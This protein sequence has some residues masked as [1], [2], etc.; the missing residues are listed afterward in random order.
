MSDVLYQGQANTFFA[1][2]YG[3]TWAITHNLLAG[4]NRMVLVGVMGF[5]GSVR[6]HSSISYTG[7]SPS[8]IRN[9][10]ASDGW[11]RVWAMDESL[12]PST[13]GNKTLSIVTTWGSV[14]DGVAFAV[15]FQN[16][17]QGVANIDQKAETDAATSTPAIASIPTAAGSMS[18]VLLAMEDNTGITVTS[19]GGLTNFINQVNS[20]SKRRF[21]M[22][23]N[24]EDAAV[25]FGM[26]NVIG[27]SNMM[28]L[29][30]YPYVA[31]IT[32]TP[33]VCMV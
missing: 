20:T 33:I 11:L 2:G 9:Y 6:A 17:L 28:A 3:D 7:G 13:T 25:T 4:T 23:R 27:V 8:L 26:S 12:L 21:T 1:S 15:Q 19:W 5:S 32:F 16:V 30:L 18:V 10:E 31:P 22:G 14:S 24:L 29:S